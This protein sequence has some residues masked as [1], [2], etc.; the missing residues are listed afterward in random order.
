ME[1]DTFID[2]EFVIMPAFCGLDMEI[3]C[4]GSETGKLH[5]WDIESGEL[6]AVLDEHSQHSG[7]M[8]FNTATPGMMASCSDDNHIIM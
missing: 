8:S 2:D 1:A 6:I 5:F 3:V 4:A 7:W